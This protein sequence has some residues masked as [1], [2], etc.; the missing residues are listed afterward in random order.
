MLCFTQ[1]QK[2]FTPC[3]WYPIKMQFN[4]ITYLCST[5]M[6]LQFAFELLDYYGDFTHIATL[7]AADAGLP[8]QGL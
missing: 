8:S 3:T 6:H 5:E 4:I 7:P 1:N 2:L